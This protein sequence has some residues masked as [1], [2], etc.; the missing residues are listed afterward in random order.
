MKGI[1]AVDREIAHDAAN[2]TRRA[3]SIWLQ[4]KGDGRVETEELPEDYIN[5]RSVDI[6]ERSIDRVIRIAKRHNLSLRR[7][8]PND[9]AGCSDLL[10]LNLSKKIRLITEASSFRRKKTN[11]ISIAIESSHWAMAKP[12]R[13][14]WHGLDLAT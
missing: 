9:D 1:S 13:G 6:G 5:W 14:L 4:A 7:L 8:Q 12:E 3:W 10:C 11:Q 2:H